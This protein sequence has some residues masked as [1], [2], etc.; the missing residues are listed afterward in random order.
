MMSIQIKLLIEHNTQMLAVH[1]R[2]IA[3]ALDVTGIKARLIS[4]YI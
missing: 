4:T 3:K 1:V 2:D